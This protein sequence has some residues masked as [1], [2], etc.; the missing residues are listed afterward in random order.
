MEF[1]TFRVYLR[2]AIKFLFGTLLFLFL[3]GLLELQGSQKPEAERNK[4]VLEQI[5]KSRGIEINDNYPTPWPPAMNA[6]YPDYELIDQEG[7]QFKLSDYKGKI[8]I[9]EMV[10]MSSPFSQAYSNAAE[11][12]LFG[13]TEKYDE[14][15]KPIATLLREYSEDNLVLPLPNV[16]TIKV[17]VQTQNGA[18]PS[19]KDAEEWAAFFRLT[20]ANNVIVAVPVKDIRGKLTEKITPG[21]QLI[22]GDMMLRVDSAGLEPKH[23]L[24]M[25]L[26]PQLQ[27][28]IGY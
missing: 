8:I 25:T 6:A 18:Q 27:K 23:N 21:Y 20:K 13:A 19:V 1:E 17:I 10:D 3:V 7:V 5:A 22:D 9:L 14:Y 16:V 4:Y 24:T 26:V 11:I 12:G 15:T 2:K 28:L